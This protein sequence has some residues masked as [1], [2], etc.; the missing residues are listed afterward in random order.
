MFFLKNH[1]PIVHIEKKL[2]VRKF[3]RKKQGFKKFSVGNLCR[4]QT[5]KQHKRFPQ[6]II[7]RIE[8]GLYFQS[9]VPG[10][11]SWQLKPNSLQ[12]NSKR[13]NKSKSFD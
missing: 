9:L 11:F 2:D 4:F 6:R 10:R 13:K 3:F 7:G 8:R 1:L 5:I 12:I